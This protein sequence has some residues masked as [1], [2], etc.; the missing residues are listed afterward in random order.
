MTTTTATEIDDAQ[1]ERLRIAADQHDDAE[2]VVDCDRA[3]AGDV[4]A[5]GRC[6]KVIDD[7]AREAAYQAAI[8]AQP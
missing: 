6:A 8:E 7:A 3:L 4:S 2:T 5:R 1:I